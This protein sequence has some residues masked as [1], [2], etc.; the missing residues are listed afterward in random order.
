MAAGHDAHDVR[1]SVYP[2]AELLDDQI[3]GKQEL[4]DLYSS[5]GWVR[6]AQAADDLLAAVQRSTY[7]VT[8]R[9]SDE[10]VGLARCMSDDVSIAYIQDIL[11]KP[12]FQRSGIGRALMEA[13]L[14]RFA[15]VRQVGLLT[16]DEERQH[17]FYESMGFR[18]ITTFDDPALHAFVVFRP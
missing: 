17:A 10:L 5:V 3:P 18:N 4:V 11:V 9:E 1:A 7:V 8:A 13:V 6:Y 15:S 16:D 12:E 14:A 2:V